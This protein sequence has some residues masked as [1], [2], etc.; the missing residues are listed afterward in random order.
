M[1]HRPIEQKQ[2]RRAAKAF[3]RR[4]LPSYFD[5]VQWLI[6]NRHAATKRQARKLILDEKVR[7]D[8]HIVG[9][10]RNQLTVKD[11]GVTTEDVVD[12]RVSVD[13]RSGLVVT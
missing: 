5:L 11:G 12:P 4:P 8:S 3:R 2:R 13:L 6:D 9:I 1:S 7:S 10:L